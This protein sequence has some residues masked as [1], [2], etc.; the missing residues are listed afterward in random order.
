MIL[1]PAHIL[2]FLSL[3]GHRAI[4]SIQAPLQ[5]SRE[6]KHKGLNTRNKNNFPCAGQHKLHQDLDSPVWVPSLP[7]RS[8]PGSKGKPF[9]P[10][11]CSR[12]A[13]R[14]VQISFGH[15]GD[16]LISH[17][18]CTSNF[19]LEIG[20]QGRSPSTGAAHRH[21]HF[22]TFRRD[23]ALLFQPAELLYAKPWC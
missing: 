3:P 2:H 22:S 18:I 21:A 1:H 10:S 7:S 4:S 20:W 8:S 9:L 19:L 6:W 23:R 14:K 5:F 17:H 13:R 15:F 11:V 12:A 16:N